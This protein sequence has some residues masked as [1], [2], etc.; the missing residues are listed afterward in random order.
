MYITSYSYL[1][2]AICALFLFS[3]SL[4]TVDLILRGADPFSCLWPVI[5]QIIAIQ[6]WSCWEQ[7]SSSTLQAWANCGWY[8]SEE[9]EACCFSLLSGFLE[10]MTNGKVSHHT[11]ML[12]ILHQLGWTDTKCLNI[13][14]WKE[15]FFFFFFLSFFLYHYRPLSCYKYM[16]LLDWTVCQY[17]HAN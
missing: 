10:I 4:S 6:P 7:R 16:Q 9:F 15:I 2:T 17:N 13:S 12:F 14:N 3:G 1:I 8:K 11:V 5:L